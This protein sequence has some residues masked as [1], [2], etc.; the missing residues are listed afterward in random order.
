M[1]WLPIIEDKVY[2]HN[3][4]VVHSF[5]H[6]Q[7]K[8]ASGEKQLANAGCTQITMVFSTKLGRTFSTKAFLGGKTIYGHNL[9][10]NFWNQ[11][12][13]IDFIG[14]SPLHKQHKDFQKAYMC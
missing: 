3:K 12:D 2:N 8:C 11:I 1:L 14:K 7:I 4:D 13:S 10:D 6:P 9:Y 5:S